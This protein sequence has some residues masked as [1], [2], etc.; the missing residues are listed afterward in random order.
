MASGEDLLDDPAS[1]QTIEIATQIKIVLG[2]TI[3]ID[4]AT[5]DQ[6]AELSNSLRC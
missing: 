6:V 4:Q 3:T 5:R 2:R 1:E